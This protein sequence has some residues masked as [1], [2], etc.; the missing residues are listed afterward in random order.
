MIVTGLDR[1]VRDLSGSSD[2]RFREMFYEEARELLIGLEE[3]LMDLERRQSDRAHLDK[4]FR[5]AHSLK[6][7]A[8]M[9][10]LASIAEFTHG[11]E[12]VLER[13]RA[14]LLSVDS[15]IITTLLEARDH[16]AAMVEAE[17]AKSP[18]PPSGE[19]TQ[20]LNSLLRGPSPSGPSGTSDPP[21]APLP[22]IHR[23]AAASCESAAG[24]RTGRGQG[25]T[26]VRGINRK[27]RAGEARSN[28]P[29]QGRGHAGSEPGPNRERR[30]VRPER[31]GHPRTTAVRPPTVGRGRR[32]GID[33]LQ[34]TLA[35]GPETLRR[36]INP[37]GVLDELRDLG[38]ATI[39]TDADVVPPLDELDPERCYLTWTITLKTD[40]E[41]DR[42]DDAFLFFAEDS[43]ITIER[44]T[45]DG[46]LV[47][48]RPGAKPPR[49]LQRTGVAAVPSREP[50]IPTVSRR[51]RRAAT[52]SPSSRNGNGAARG[53]R[54]DFCSGPWPAGPRVA[55]TAPAM[56]R[57]HARIRVD[58]GQ[59]DDL[60]GLAGELVVV[61]DN[62]MGLREIAR[63]WNPGSMRSRHWSGSAGRSGTRRSTCGWFR[64]T[65]CSRGSRGWS[66]TWPT[67]RARRSSCGSSAR[68]RGSTA[69]SSSGSPTR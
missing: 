11:I 10:G 37:L 28:T 62:L 51:D 53:S 69:R 3:G 15:D 16:L 39:A 26:G 5:A 2:D 67:G 22:R 24:P 54:R 33:G 35:P 20:R 50:S 55:A 59:L 9:V 30:A 38:E 34:I 63:R 27:E 45:P 4:T 6:G 47:P 17:A 29:R 66:A 52:G 41:P 64:S 58:A 61:S 40:V 56:P 48:V 49:P 18:I 31:W 19:L 23:A 8:A 21:P 25:S 46:K 1:G 32:S 13:V 57:P 44:M 42:I 7:A 60:V 14:G 43:A 12:A 36:G 68:K 65:S